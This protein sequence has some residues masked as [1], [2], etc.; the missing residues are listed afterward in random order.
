MSSQR[1]VKLGNVIVSSLAIAVGGL[2]L[3]WLCSAVQSA[4][5][6]ARR[7]QQT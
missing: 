3:T 6:A 5:N 7:A 1:L 2:L 4:Q